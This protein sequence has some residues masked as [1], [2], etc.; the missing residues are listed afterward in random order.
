MHVCEKA[1]HC[2]V[3]SNYDVPCALFYS[4]LGKTFVVQWPTIR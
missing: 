4:Y 2:S 3:I 1:G